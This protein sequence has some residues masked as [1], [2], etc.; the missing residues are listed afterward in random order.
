MTNEFKR[1]QLVWD[2][3]SNRKGRFVDYARDMGISASVEFI[4]SYNEQTKQ[5]TTKLENVKTSDLRVYREKKP[6]DQRKKGVNLWA[7][8]KPN[9]TI[10]SKR[11]EDAGRDVYACFEG[12]ELLLKKLQANKVP[13]GIAS[14]IPP[15]HYW[16]I[17]HERGSSGKYTML[18]LSG[19]IDSGY[20]GEWFINICPLH[21]DVVISKTYNFPIEDGQKK[22][23]ELEDKIMYP[24]EV[25]IA[26]AVKLPVPDDDDKEIAYEQLKNIKSERGTDIE[27]SSGK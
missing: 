22:P 7:K 2:M 11:N 10:P 27:G 17:K 23:I 25:A 18:L 1:G 3:G 24:Y 9:A 13:T 12:N 14:A 6:Y 20:R 19:C 5:R 8:V 4:I 21:K 26:Q 16:N 15:T